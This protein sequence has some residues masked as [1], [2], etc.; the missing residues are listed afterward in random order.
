MQGG[1]S[2]KS[3]VRFLVTTEA[4]RRSSE[5]S[6]EAAEKDPLNDLLQHM[7]LRRL[8]AEAIR[9][10]VLAVSGQLDYEMF[11]ESIKTYYAKPAT[12][13]KQAKDGK[14]LGPMDG[15]RRRSIYLEVRRNV[16]NPYLEVFDAPKRYECSRAVI[17]Y[18][19]FSVH[20][21]GVGKMG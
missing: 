11:G 19:E 3:M 13:K 17:D 10:A 21:P 15:A 20:Y 1:L 6:A 2:I 5:V 18:D 16:S 9:D 8:E 14:T 7:P 12:D 4:Y